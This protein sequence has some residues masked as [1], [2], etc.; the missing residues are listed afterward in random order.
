MRRII[1]PLFLLFSLPAF[2][3][4]EIDGAAL[5]KA[6]SAQEARLFRDKSGFF[7]EIEGDR[8]FIAAE[9]MDSALRSMNHDDVKRFLTANYIRLNR[10]QNKYK[11]ASQM[12][13]KGGGPVCGAIGGVATWVVGS[14]VLAVTAAARA[15]SGDPVGAVGTVAVGGP[16]VGWLGAKV[17]GILTA[18]P[19]IP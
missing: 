9:N 13:L 15:M 10:I 4:F 18:V 16:T 3:L 8:Q 12:R 7:V 17:A 1:L 5:Q 14:G 6:P 11:L 2:A 19:F